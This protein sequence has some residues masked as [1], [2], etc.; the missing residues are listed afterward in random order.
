M[1]NIF[2]ILTIGLLSL[3]LLAACGDSSNNNTVNDNSNNKVNAN[4]NTN[5]EDN[6]V[7]AN[8][9]D[10]DANNNENNNNDA[11]SDDK[12]QVV[13]SFTLIEDIVLEIGGDLVE[14]YN[15]VPIGTDPHEYEYLP[16]DIKAT[17]DADILVYNGVNLEGGKDG[18]FF[19]LSKA[20]ETDEENIYEAGAGV[21]P[22]YL[23]S[24]DGTEEEINPH[25]FLDPVN[26]ILMAEN[27][28]KG[29]VDADPDNKEIY[30]ENAEAYLDQLKEVDDLYE[31]KINELPEEK[32]ILVTSE[33]AYQYM[34][35][36][37]GLKEGFIWAIDTE[38]GGT[39]EQITNAIDFVEENAP[40]VLFVES[41]VDTRP[42]ET[43][44][45]ET[46]VEIYED[47]IYSDELG[48]PGTEG[49]IYLRWLKY[50]INTIYEGLSQ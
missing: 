23:A 35:N 34:A 28:H 7:N 15:L 32:R 41:N 21:D 17:T 2:K 47:M 30:D 38:E 18:W 46:G 48:E 24:E 49:D 14:T 39:P 31:E 20:T 22:M 19:K 33:R 13:T 36:R 11:S 37:Y 8:N 43:V 40:P 25:I 1:R 10:T 44:S 42:M 27:I 3:I 6:E 29:L 16:D 26:G 50:N 12:L 4:N 9:N 5:N 45:D